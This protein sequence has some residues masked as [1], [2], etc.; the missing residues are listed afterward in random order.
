MA[1]VFG[2]EAFCNSGGSNSSPLLKL[3]E[4]LKGLSVDDLN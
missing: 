3:K 2:N 4:G 1:A